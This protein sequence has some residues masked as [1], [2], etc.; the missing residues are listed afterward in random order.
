MM[1]VNVAILTDS[2]HAE[3]LSEALLEHGALSS[4]IEDALAGTPAEQPQF[5]E[6]GMP[7]AP[8][9]DHSRVVALFEKDAQLLGHVTA[10][11]HAAGLDDLPDFEL[12]EVAEQN[13]VQLTQSQFEP[14]RVTDRLWIVPTWHDAPDPGAIN[15]ALDPGMAFG[16]GSHPTT[17]LCLQWLEASLR[18]GEQLADYGCGSGILAIAAAKLGAS[19]VLGTD[20]DPQ[21]LL[22]ARDNAA[23]NGVRLRL[24]DAQQP[25]SEQFDVVVANILA[26]PLTVL[27]PALI[28]LTRRGGRIAL[29]GILAAQAEQVRAAYAPDIALDVA[30]ERDGWILM[31]GERPC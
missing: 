4:S 2:A 20:I 3:A 8:L 15:I 14:I 21:A 27:A 12:E 10:A 24:V 13:W 11:C 23:Q 31:T 19:D 22:A 16:T 17:W 28:A 6:P 7:G 26:N 30:A 29:S 9:W 25:I 1:W 18:G 5:G